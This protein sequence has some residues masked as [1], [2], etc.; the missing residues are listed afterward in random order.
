MISKKMLDKIEAASVAMEK[1]DLK[2]MRDKRVTLKAPVPFEYFLWVMRNSK[3][4][5][6][7]E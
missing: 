1:M 2:H 3:G 4:L 5:R 6:V 7:V